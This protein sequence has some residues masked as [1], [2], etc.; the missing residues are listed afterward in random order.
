MSEKRVAEVKSE[1][2]SE[3]KVV[4]IDQS[5][6]I[7]DDVPII[8]FVPN[9]EMSMSRYWEKIRALFDDIS[10]RKLEKR[11][12]LTDE[13]SKI[14]LMFNRPVEISESDQNIICSIADRLGINYGRFFYSWKPI[15]EYI[16]RY[17]GRLFA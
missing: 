14:A 9:T 4:G 15:K 11:V 5:Q 17:N 13:I 3:L 7:S 2:H 1:R 16:N 8:R 10:V 6:H 12:E